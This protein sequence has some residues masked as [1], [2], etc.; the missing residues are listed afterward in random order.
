LLVRGTLAHPA[1]AVQEQHAA[2]LLIDR[3]V[4]K[5]INCAAADR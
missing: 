5:D 2:L 4:A 3:G 1:I